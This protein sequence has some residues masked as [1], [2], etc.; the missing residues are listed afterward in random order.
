MAI[1]GCTA[2]FFNSTLDFELSSCEGTWDNVKVRN[3]GKVGE[4][5]EAVEAGLLDV[6]DA[7]INSN[8][9]HRRD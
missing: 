8:N 6:V 1:E 4:V 2:T 7:M 3:V 9:F 5:D